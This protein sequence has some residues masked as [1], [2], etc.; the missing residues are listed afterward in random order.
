MQIAARYHDLVRADV[1]SALPQQGLG[2][3]LDFG[4]GVG[5]TGAALKR[6]GRASFVALA[7]QV[8][9][10]SVRDID[11][12]HSGNLEDADFLRNMLEQSGPF[13]TILALDV[14]EHLRDPW[15]VVRL[16]HAGLK[17]NGVIVASI[18]N[19]NYH[20]LVAPL[21]FRG[22]FDLTDS[23]ILDRTHIRWF[24]KHGAI[25]LMASSGLQIELVAPNVFGRKD[26]LL[27]RASFGR[28]T[29]F[30]ALQY[31]ISARRVD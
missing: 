19:V 24:A 2:R 18:P 6:A 14:M 17:R 3:L 31:I 8:A 4:G 15:A 23:G 1:F 5:A 25:E 10:N 16:L 27:E 28:L 26:R 21:V 13:D 29:R 7:D 20:G 9:D 12:A 30:V 11:E 22:R